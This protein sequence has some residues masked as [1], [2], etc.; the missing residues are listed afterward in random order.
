M[1]SGAL[2]AR[3]CWLVSC[4]WAFGS[5]GDPA[6]DERLCDASYSFLVRQL[7]ASDL[8][9]RLQAAHVL[10]SLVRAA[11]REDVAQLVP[12]ATQ[13]LV[14]LAAI[15]GAC[16]ADDGCLWT[17]RAMGAFLRRVGLP[18]E[19]RA[20]VVP[21][22]EAVWQRAEREQRGLLLRGMRAVAAAVRA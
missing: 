20:G 21:V 17:L 7:A 8:A 9:V 5:G 22:L 14:G 18:A 6:E 16:T 15:L 3:L 4:W 2:Q 12:H 1:L 10:S 19:A 11:G 13:A